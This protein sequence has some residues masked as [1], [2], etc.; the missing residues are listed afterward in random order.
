VKIVDITRV[1]RARIRA[2]NASCDEAP[3]SAGQCNDPSLR[4][5]SLHDADGEID[6][7]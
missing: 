6:R 3:T 7:G 4:M 5:L 2:L 1:V